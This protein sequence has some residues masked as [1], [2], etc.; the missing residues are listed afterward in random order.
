MPRKRPRSL[1]ESDGLSATTNGASD[2]KI[3][4]FGPDLFRKK[5]RANLHMATGMYGS[6]NIHIRVL[7][8][9]VLADAQMHAFDT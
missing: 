7:L 1:A 3:Y 4:C 8:T 9:I 2:T 5:C 6:S